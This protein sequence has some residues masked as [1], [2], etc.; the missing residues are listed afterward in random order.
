MC[1][2]IHS[3][4]SLLIT[5]HVS[6]FAFWIGYLM[7]PKSPVFYIANFKVLIFNFPNDCLNYPLYPGIAYLPKFSA[8]L[9]ADQRRL[10]E[11]TGTDIRTA[12]AIRGHRR[13]LPAVGELTFGTE[14]QANGMIVFRSFVGVY[15]VNFILLSLYRVSII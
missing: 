12:Q 13:L 10:L 8:R 15:I 11:E 5:A 2:G 4:N 7:P 1:F 6:S 9:G 3:C 14:E